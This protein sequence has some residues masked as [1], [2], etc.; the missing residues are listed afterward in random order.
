MTEIPDSGRKYWA[1]KTEETAL[2]VASQQSVQDKFHNMKQKEV[3]TMHFVCSDINSVI[4]SLSALIHILGSCC[5]FGLNRVHQL[6]GFVCENCAVVVYNIK[7]PSVFSVL[8]TSF[9]HCMTLPQFRSKTS[10]SEWFLCVKHLCNWCCFGQ[11][12]INRGS[13]SNT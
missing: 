10:V 1:L 9:L 8:C 7:Y 6:V 5:P 2:T 4:L 3:L 13:S 11:T 12:A